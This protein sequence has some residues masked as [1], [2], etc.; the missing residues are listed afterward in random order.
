MGLIVNGP[1]I[2]DCGVGISVPKGSDAVINQPVM[3][4]NGKAIEERDEPIDW[5]LNGPPLE[6]LKSLHE[7]LAAK[8]STEVE[9]VQ[10]IEK[11]GLNRWV[12]GRTAAEIGIH[13]I[14]NPAMIQQWIELVSK[15]VGGASA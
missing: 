14:K 5:R 2:T 12:I 1:T 3:S 4:R 9:A 8:P 13:A 10:V 6:V 7:Y 15:Y 11:T